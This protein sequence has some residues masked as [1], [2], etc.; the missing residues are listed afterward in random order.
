MKRFISVLLA[1]SMIISSVSVF[2]VSDGAMQEMSN[3]KFK[4]EIIVSQADSEK[5][6]TWSTSSLMNYDETRTTYASSDATITFKPTGLKKGNY[7][8]Y[9][10]VPLHPQNSKQNFT[11]NHNGKAT[12]T[13]AYFK[14]ICFITLS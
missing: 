3:E 14:N 6:G 13:F 2:A 8:L 5:T 11:V 9:Y 1:F 4:G 10:W 12:T 7:E